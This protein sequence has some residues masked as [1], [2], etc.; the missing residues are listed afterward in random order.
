[1]KTVQ[2]TESARVFIEELMNQH[3]VKSIRVFVAGTGCCSG[4]KM[5]VALEEPSSNDVVETINGIQVAI[6][7]NALANS[8][9]ITIDY[10]ETP[11][12]SGLVMLGN[13]NCC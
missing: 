7:K 5:G 8:Q 11:S 10:Q 13:D 6:E 12:G 3:D 4:P 1:V 9:A 2:I